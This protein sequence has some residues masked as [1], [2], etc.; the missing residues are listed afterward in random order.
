MLVKMFYKT[1]EV[2]LNG[3]WTETKKVF[4]VLYP[5]TGE[6][7]FYT[8]EAEQ[9]TIRRCI[10]KY[11]KLKSSLHSLLPLQKRRKILREAAEGIERKANELAMTISVEAGK[12][13]RYA[14]I[15]VERAK[16]TFL[17]ASELLGHS[18]GELLEFGNVAGYRARMG[19]VKRFPV[20]VVLAITPFNFPLNL[21]SHKVAPAIAGGNA[22]II[23]PS[24]KTPIT[25]LK[26]ADILLQA[27]YPAELLSVVPCSNPLAEQMAQSEIINLLSF[28]GS[29][30]VGWHLK[31]TVGK[32]RVLLELGG[33]AAAY[34]HPDADLPTAARQCAYGAFVYA[35]QICISLQRLYIHHEIY[36]A[37]I[38]MLLEETQKITVGD[39]ADINTVCG[40]LISKQHYERILEWI[41][42]SESKGAKRLIGGEANP[43]NCTIQPC[44]LENVSEKSKLYKQEAFGPVLCVYA[45]KD[46]DEAIACVNRSDYGLQAAIFTH[47]EGLIK[48]FFH[49]VEVGGVVVNEAPYLRFDGMPYGGVKDSGLGREGIYYAYQEMTEPRLLLW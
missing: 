30:K 1:F 6:E 44:I 31:S 32:K 38:A 47:H 19:L 13:I 35:G 48:Q 27:G 36:D 25:A 23:K 37:F 29:A 42:E 2:L 11:E 26:L 33:N 20:G 8:Y 12:P 14:E 40:P 9:D 17:L 46:I 34:V 41:T 49:E 7:I 18:R 4:P 3:K 10:N 21:V 28:T 39:P 45:V 15:E 16:E 24:P 22:I 5:F 43:Q